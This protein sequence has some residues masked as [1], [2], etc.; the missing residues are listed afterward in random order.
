VR[1]HLLQAKWKRWLIAEARGL[2]YT[3]SQFAGL[4]VHLFLATVL[5][6]KAG[7]FG[8]FITAAE[9]LDVNY[10][11]LMRAMFLNGLGGQS[12]TIVEPTARP[13]ADAASTAVIGTFEIGSKPKSIGVLATIPEALTVAKQSA[14]KPALK[15]TRSRQMEAAAELC[16]AMSFSE[17]IPFV[18]LGIVVGF[19]GGLYS[20]RRC[21][22][23]D[24]TAQR[25]FQ[26]ET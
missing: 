24:P 14:S 16:V 13:F 15:T 12:L 8:S 22:N 10:G 6:A 4:H 7:D 5:Q 11:R 25:G 19:A 9:W 26:I 23:R 2:G 18:A 21:V 20:F 17:V 3:A 1:H